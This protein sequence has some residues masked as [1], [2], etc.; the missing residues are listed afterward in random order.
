MKLLHWIQKQRNRKAG[1]T[2]VELIVVLVI[3]AILAALLVPALTGYI[4]KAKE[5][6]VI[7]ETRT[8]LTAIQTEVSEMYATDD[9]PKNYSGTA[10]V[11]IADKTGSGAI[12]DNY[13]SIVSLAE[14]PSLNSDGNGSFCCAVNSEGKVR[15]LIYEAGNGYL[16]LYFTE[17]SEYIA[18]KPVTD[19]YHLHYST[20]VNKVVVVR[21]YTD[22]QDDPWG[23]GWVQYNLGITNKPY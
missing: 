17:T 7:A 12:S 21:T 9:F 4:D 1:F 3:L 2:L 16:G 11:S 18:Y 6:Q 8:L 20:Y 15:T 22:T 5:K 14:L 10:T 23:P 13:T 19:T